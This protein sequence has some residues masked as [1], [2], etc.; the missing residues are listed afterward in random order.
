MNKKSTLLLAASALALQVAAQGKYT[1]SGNLQ[2]AEGQKIYLSIGDAGNNEIDSTVIANG[3]FTFKGEMQVPFQN[4]SLLLGNLK[5]YQTLKMWQVA[6]EPMNITVTGDANDKESV[7]IK[8]G[9]VQEELDRMNQEMAVFEQPIISL[10]KA[11]YAQQTQEGKDSI[12]HLMEPYRKQYQEFVDN[13]IQSHTDSYFATQ[14]LSLNMGKMTYEDI[15]T[16]WERLT[17]E[18]QKYGINAKAIKNELDVM[19]KVRPGKS[20][21]DFTTQ[22]INGKSFTLSSLK[23]KVVIIDFWAS[24]CVPCRKSNPHMRELYAKYHSKGLDMV[25]VADDDSNPE[26]WKKAVEKDQLVGDGFHHVLR[27]LKMDTAKGTFDRT[28]DISEKYA[29]HFLPTKYLID[30]KGNIVCKINEGEDAQLDAEIV[31]LLNDK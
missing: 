31:K 4:G 14:Y 7:V 22:D 29:I 15:K 8:G 27:G 21:P 3:K 28:H 19:A 23:G 30:R 9:K 13:Y 17:P 16:A 26:K 11:Y 10:N 18:V 20:A 25:Y 24:W 1:I 12:N 5:D 2:N 6:I